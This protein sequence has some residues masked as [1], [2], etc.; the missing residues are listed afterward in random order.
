MAGADR[1]TQ[2]G[3]GV[4]ITAYRVDPANH[5]TNG[6]DIRFGAGQ[7]NI[8]TSHAILTAGEQNSLEDEGTGTV[9][10]IGFD[11][12]PAFGGLGGSNTEASYSFS[13]AALAA[14]LTASL[15]WNL[16]VDETDPYDAGPLLYDL[17][18][19]LWDSSTGDDVQVASSTSDIDNTE[20]IWFM[21]AAG[22][23]YTLQVVNGGVGDFVW[24]Y[25]LAWNLR[26][27]PLPGAFPMFTLALIGVLLRS[28]AQARPS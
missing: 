11:Y 19:L 2:N 9:L 23:A 13:V 12:D 28:R 3:S 15:V 16:S 1:R 14:E 10:P 20:N 26:A 18:L 21:L 22:G 25:A 24:D 5:S 27:V 6:L 8:A 7:L 17:D 4:D